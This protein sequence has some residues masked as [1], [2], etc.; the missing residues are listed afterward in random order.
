MER[1]E[2][3]EPVEP[4][5]EIGSRGGTGRRLA[6]NTLHAASGRVLSVLLWL[7][8][9]PRIL[10]AVGTEGYAIWS[11]F[12]ALTGYLS[13]FDLGLVQGTLRH[14]AGARARDAH[15]EA[16]AFA[17]L[18]ILG[19]FALGLV[20]IAVLFLLGDF[21][22]RLL[23]VPPAQAGVARFAL[24]AGGAAFALAGVV[25][26]VMSVLQAYGRFDLAN[27]VAVAI[28][29]FQGLGILLALRFGLGLRGLVLGMMGSWLLGMLCAALLL[30]MK[31]REFRFGSW[32]RARPHVRE[33][34]AFGG[35]MQLAG[36]FSALHQQIDKFLLGA[37]IALAA[38]T[39]YELGARVAISASVFPQFLLLAVLPTAAAFH[40]TQDRERLRELY[41]RGARFVLSAGAI[42][43]AVVLGAGSRVF[44]AWL[45]PG[46][47]DSAMVLRALA[48]GFAAALTTGMGTT[49]V[50]GIGR[51]DVEA[52]FAGVVAGSH[53]LL[54]LVLIP[55]W[56]LRGALVAWIVSNAAGSVYFLARFRSL[57]GWTRREVFLTPHLVPTLAVA[58]G[59]LCALALDR[60]MPASAGLVAWIAAGALGGVSALVV[61]G[62][63]TA[64]RYV[65][66]EE[67][68]VLLPYPRRRAAG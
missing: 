35:P 58:A 24:I 9:T 29:I 66:L 6:T 43:L 39:P 59:W 15:E 67:V 53:L 13:A 62:V 30:R 3:V 22:L 61:L 11:L 56:G 34:L 57:F 47:E 50:R 8:F 23:H 31:V 5:I 25:N 2:P 28:T 46:H 12:F 48:I 51:P 36:I 18:G 63:L 55:R 42:V 65:K 38:I 21:A 32:P 19:F 52:R 27:S 10:R 44:I 45:G 49:L 14:V 1:V 26:V 41:R 20:W 60:V 40:A 37:F 64:A 68:R 4:G 16:G 54:S 17:T 33:A 7:V